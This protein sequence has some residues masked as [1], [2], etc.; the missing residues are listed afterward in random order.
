MGFDAENKHE[1]L[2]FANSLNNDPAGIQGLNVPKYQ[3][4]DFLPRNLFHKFLLAKQQEYIEL[5]RQNGTEVEFCNSKVVNIDVNLDVV[6]ENGSQ[7][8]AN[9]II[10]TSGLTYVQ[11]ENFENAISVFEFDFERLADKTAK[12]HIIGSG[13]N[14]IDALFSLDSV[15]FRGQINIISSSGEF[16]STHANN[17]SPYELSHSEFGSI[18]LSLSRAMS[19]IR[20]EIKSASNN[21][22]EWQNVLDAFGP[23]LNQLWQNIRDTDRQKFLNRYLKKWNKFRH[24]MPIS[25]MTLIERLFN[26]DRLTINKARVTNIDDKLILL[27]NQ[28]EV[29]VGFEDAIIDCRGPTFPQKPKYLE[30]LIKK[31]KI[32]FNATFGIDTVYGSK[33]LIAHEAEK[34][35]Y[36]IG[37]SHFG[38]RI[39]T[40]SVPFL[41]KDAISLVSE[42]AYT[43]S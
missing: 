43:V 33:F 22:I 23:H 40:T 34:K 38:N 11:D 28:S 37:A 5:L 35:L 17:F 21:S 20:R 31:G 39:E 29:T 15:N 4:S 36:T 1:F 41:I 26:Q 27:S 14:A 8:S 12:V 9:H 25:A 6:C 19:I 3:P 7:F 2:D 16:P 32:K 13:L 18:N 24:R 10:C 30:F 42:I